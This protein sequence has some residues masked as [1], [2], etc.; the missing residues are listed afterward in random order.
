VAFEDAIEKIAEKL[1]YSDGAARRRFI[2]G[3]MLALGVALPNWAVIS[4]QLGGLTI[5]DLLKTPLLAATAG[6]LIYLG[7]TIVEMCGMCFSS[8]QPQHSFA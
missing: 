1:P 2:A 4:K 3:A 6:L 7:G 8:R 5:L